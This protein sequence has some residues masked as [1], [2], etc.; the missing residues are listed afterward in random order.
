MKI[1]KEARAFVNANATGK[2]AKY[3]VPLVCAAYLLREGGV[4]CPD[5]PAVEQAMWGMLSGLAASGAG[6]DDDVCASA[7]LSEAMLD[8]KP[9]RKWKRNGL[10][11]GIKEVG[12]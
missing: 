6:I 5:S 4:S 11:Y 9:P 2:V 8:V 3:F 12:A 7:A 1:T 10:A